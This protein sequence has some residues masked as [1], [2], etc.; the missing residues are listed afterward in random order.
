[1]IR[2]R[3]PRRRR[4]SIPGLDITPQVPAGRQLIR[5]YGS[6]QFHIAADIHQGS[7]L[8]FPDRTIAWPVAEVADITLDSLALMS[9]GEAAV[10]ILVLGC[11]PKFQAPPEGL[12]E[13]LREWGVVLEW[14]D[15]GAASRTFNVLLAEDRACAAA[16]IAVE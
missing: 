14:M 9:G 2:R 5:S 7:V 4:N 1:M 6:G 16:L 15:T 13:G 3:W 11:G 8:V 10:E 12:R